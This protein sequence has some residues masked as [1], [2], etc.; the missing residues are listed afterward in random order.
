MRALTLYRK[1]EHKPSHF[2]YTFKKLGTHTMEATITPAGEDW[3]PINNKFYKSVY[4]VP[5]PKVIAITDDASSPL[6]QIIESL[7]TVDRTDSVPDNLTKFRSVVI[8]NKGAAML[9]VISQEL[10]W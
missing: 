9:G 7:Y 8:D 6:Y 1:N 3:F 10:C 5:K 4:V 2:S